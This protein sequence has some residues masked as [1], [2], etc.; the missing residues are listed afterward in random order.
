MGAAVAESQ[1]SAGSRE[2]EGA[3][4]TMERRREGRS[5]TGGDGDDDDDEADAEGE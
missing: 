2:V 5:G 4:T 1:F 3:A